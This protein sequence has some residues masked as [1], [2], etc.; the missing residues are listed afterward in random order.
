MHLFFFKIVFEWM[1]HVQ[2][3]KLIL[4]TNVSRKPAHSEVGVFVLSKFMYNANAESSAILKQ[5]ERFKG[6]TVMYVDPSLDQMARWVLA[7]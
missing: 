2:M 4:R 6:L 7:K 3:L 5:F 1:L